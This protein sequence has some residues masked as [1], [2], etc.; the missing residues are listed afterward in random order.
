MEDFRFMSKMS[1][2][3]AYLFKR[4]IRKLL[5][6]T[7]I[8]ADKD[9]KLYDYISSESNQYDVNTYLHAIG[10]QVIVED[11]MKVAMLQQNDAD[12]D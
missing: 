11:R 2:E 5:D 7:F 3:D 6:V 1:D 9:E 4:C 8:V 12:V 10:Y